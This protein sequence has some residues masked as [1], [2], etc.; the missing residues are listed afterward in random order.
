MTLYSKCTCELNF[1][2]F[3]QDKR[4]RLTQDVLMEFAEQQGCTRV[5]LGDS[6]STVAARVVSDSTKGLALNSPHLSLHESLAGVCVCVCVCVC[7]RA[8][9]CV[10]VCV[11]NPKAYTYNMY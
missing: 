2:N 7:V 1:Q 11:Y 10:C 8:C 3:C 6:A 9:A 4:E 5:V